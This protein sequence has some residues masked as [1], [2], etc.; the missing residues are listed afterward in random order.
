MKAPSKDYLLPP[1]VSFDDGDCQV[2]SVGS[3]AWVT[4]INPFRLIVPDSES[5]WEASL[6]EINN[7]TYDHG[8]LS[9]I[10]AQLPCPLGPTLPMFV[11]YDGALAIAQFG[12]FKAKEN[13]VQFFNRVLCDLLIG[14]IP[15][16]AI[17]CRDV[18]WGNLYRREY[19]WPVDFGDSAS[20][21]LHSCLRL[22]SA[23]GPI[24]TIR[25]SK[26]DTHLLSRFTDAFRLGASITSRM[27]T[28]SPQFLLLGITDLRYRNWSSA[29]ANL[30]V[31]VEQLTDHIWHEIFLKNE[32][33]HP[34]S[35]IKKRMSMLEDDNRTWSTSVK[36][37]LL[38]QAGIITD[39]VLRAVFPARQARNNLVHSGCQVPME[40][41]NAAFDGVIRL[42]E[43]C[44]G[45]S[46]P[47]KLESWCT[48][49]ERHGS[50]TNESEGNTLDEWIELSKKAE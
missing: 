15:C 2:G 46:L 35:A 20:S 48:P 19:I 7:R 14:G 21:H 4:Y 3:R 33:F 45:D 10:I 5:P 47:Y 29:L 6:D 50:G 30:W 18:V 39:E 27:P 37:E 23:A 40:A 36:Q 43:R 25:L 9:K 32:D 28:F 13:A 16:E 22:R 44:V 12:V 42:L 24:Q 49:M 31:A 26:P 38:F 11:C 17:D 41:A 8:R 1:P 34:K